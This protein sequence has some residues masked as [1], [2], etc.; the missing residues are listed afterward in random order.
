MTS[1][2]NSLIHNSRSINY[3]LFTLERISISCIFLLATFISGVAHSGEST[4][5]SIYISQVKSWH[6]PSD[7]ELFIKTQSKTYRATFANDCAGLSSAYT[8]AF[9]TQQDKHLDL[10]TV[11][12]LPDGS[13]CG[14]SSF[15][16]FC[17]GK[18]KC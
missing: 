4:H 6:A 14:L 1:N 10:S 7:Q 5:K 16:H 12:R 15:E 2:Q 13:R 17:E 11:V 9:I 3:S 8:I 18:E